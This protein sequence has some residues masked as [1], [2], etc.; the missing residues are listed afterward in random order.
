MTL[1]QAEFHILLT[2]AAGPRHGYGIMQDIKA[3]TDGSVR[4]GP[5]TLYTAIKRL[6]H[7]GLVDECGADETRRRCYRLSRKGRRVASAEAHRLSAVVRA[8]EQRGLLGG[9]A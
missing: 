7:D 9:R 2:L 8:A 3:D 4:I 1:T 5:G 6:R